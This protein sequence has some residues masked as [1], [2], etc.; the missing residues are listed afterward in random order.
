MEETRKVVAV[1]S[2]LAWRQGDP[3]VL[4][5]IN[6]GRKLGVTNGVLAT[7]PSAANAHVCRAALFASYVQLENALVS[8]TVALPADVAVG[9]LTYA[10]VKLGAGA[11]QTAKSCF[12]G[13]FPGWTGNAGCDAAFG[14]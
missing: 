14:V 8:A 1:N 13:A 10:A 11:Y 9:S 7:R 3:P 12:R 2:S 4:E 6:S 5:V